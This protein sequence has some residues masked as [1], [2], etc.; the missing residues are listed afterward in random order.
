MCVARLS[1][2]DKKSSHHDIFNVR[3]DV[4]VNV[5][6]INLMSLCR[7]HVCWRPP[8]KMASVSLTVYKIFKK[9]CALDLTDPARV[10]LG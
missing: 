4:N 8:R 5:I 6:V 7:G 10:L 3:H 2:L 9:Q 1:V